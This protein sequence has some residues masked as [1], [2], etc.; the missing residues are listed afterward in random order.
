VEEVRNTPGA[1][2]L[3]KTR[4]TNPDGWLG[5]TKEQARIADQSYA[6]VSAY[7]L[8][9]ARGVAPAVDT[10]MHSQYL[11]MVWQTLLADVTFDVTEW[12]QQRGVMPDGV[13]SDEEYARIMSS[14]MSS[15]GCEVLRAQ[16]RDLINLMEKN[17]SNGDTR[18]KIYFAA[19]YLFMR[20]GMTN[21]HASP[22]TPTDDAWDACARAWNH[23]RL[24]NEALL[25]R[26]PALKGQ[27]ELSNRKVAK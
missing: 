22:S 8:S 5:F 1:F 25:A 26:D 19:D 15:K 9:K 12:T 21:L 6:D 16:T 14:Y 4:A 20:W 13:P 3:G 23:L 18:L 27:H 24:T 7:Q 10:K 2:A 11:E 17:D